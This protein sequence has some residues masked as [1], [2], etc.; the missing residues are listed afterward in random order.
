M[1]PHQAHELLRR[2][3]VPYEDSEVLWRHAAGWLLVDVQ[4]A[5][6]GVDAEAGKVHGL[7]SPCTQR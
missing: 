5:A 1:L 2:L 4:I 6:A 7:A 3:A